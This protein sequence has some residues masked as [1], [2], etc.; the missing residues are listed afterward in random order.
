MRHRMLSLVGRC[1][2]LFLLVSGMASV[3][4]AQT[5]AAPEIDPAS[6]ASAVAILAGAALLARDKMLRR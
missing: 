2:G 1:T 6:A 5:G 4:F 3:A